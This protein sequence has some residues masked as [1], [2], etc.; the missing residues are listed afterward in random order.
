MLKN[1]LAE[2]FGSVALPLRDTLT[3]DGRPSK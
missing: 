3:E 1:S 2:T